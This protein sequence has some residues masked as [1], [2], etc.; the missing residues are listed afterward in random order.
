MTSITHKSGPRLPARIW[1]AEVTRAKIT[2][3]ARLFALQVLPPFMTRAG[4]I[5]PGGREQ[6]IRRYAEARGRVTYTARRVRQLLAELEGAGLLARD[7]RAAPGRAATYAALAP[8]SG[9]PRE[10]VV[11]PRGIGTG[12]LLA[13]WR[14]E[15]DSPAR[16]P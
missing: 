12:R 7:G 6:L 2:A 3:S 5:I 1:R 10:M 11:R 9:L 15:A 14:R 16:A 4:R 8:A 13:S